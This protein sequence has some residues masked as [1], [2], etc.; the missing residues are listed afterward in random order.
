MIIDTGFFWD[1]WKGVVI[2]MK[3]KKHLTYTAA[4]C[5]LLLVAGCTEPSSTDSSG[6][7]SATQ[8]KPSVSTKSEPDETVPDGEFSAEDSSASGG[9]SDI[10]ISIPP[11]DGSTPDETVP[12]D[13]SSFEPDFSGIYRDDEEPKLEDIVISPIEEKSF[14]FKKTEL[15]IALNQ[16]GKIPYEFYPVGTTDQTLKW[17]TS[18]SDI[19]AVAPDGTLTGL[20]LG[21]AV[22][23]AV[24]V[25]GNTATCTVTVVKEIPLSPMAK[26][27]Q[28]YANGN[29]TDKSF[30]LADVNFDGTKELIA[31]VYGENGF[32]VVT[33]L[34][35]VSG[36][37]LATF[38]TGADEEWGIWKRKD[39]S[40]YLLL[41]YT[42]NY[43][44]GAVR[45]GLDEI[46]CD[47][48]LTFSP[49]MAREN[50]NGSN[51]YYLRENGKLQTC[52]YNGYQ[53]FRQTYFAANQQ[54]AVL[55]LVWMGGTDAE[56]IATAL[57]AAKKK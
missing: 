28:S 25:K 57:T 24:T 15:T 44:S 36:N 16:N 12:E 22:I 54:T 51:T 9:I 3:L 30:A 5:L 19:V 8:S 1:F 21:K 4:L 43:P 55:E 13:E 45:Y 33:I 35:T 40:K 49:L 10:V 27:I 23:T 52:D 29:L 53:A 46:T 20:R 56:E 31:R 11:E 26:L 18:A 17:S 32:P 38:T 50:K 48:G 34:D 47:N 14:A 41:S 6:E 39:G 2:G 42:Q 37:T 7:A